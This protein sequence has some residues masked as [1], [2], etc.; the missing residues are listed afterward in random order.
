MSIDDADLARAAGERYVDRAVAG[1]IEGVLALFDDDAELLPMPPL[2]TTIRGLAALRA[3]FVAHGSGGDAEL[4]S[5]RSVAQGR[6]CCIEAHVYLRSRD[7]HLF[8]VDVF[9]VTDAGKIC[10]LAA[11]R[12]AADGE[13]GSG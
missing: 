9:T 10:R 2:T 6:R 11:Y 3:F 7:E 13:R 5:M 8:V 4:R 12:R 1:D